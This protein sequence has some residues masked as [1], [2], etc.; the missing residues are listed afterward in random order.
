MIWARVERELGRA[1][2]FMN[3]ISPQSPFFDTNV[4]VYGSDPSAGEKHNLARVLVLDTWADKKVHISIQVLQEFFYTVTRK[5]R[6]PL[7]PSQARKVIGSFSV[8]RTHSPKQEDVMAAIDLHQELKISFWDAMILQSAI[9]LG[10]D[11]IYSEDF[12]PNRTYRGIKVIN[13]FL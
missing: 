8:W 11:T 3:V 12:D 1:T 10:C 9:A 2:N 6:T 7:E 4:L 5:I 13:P